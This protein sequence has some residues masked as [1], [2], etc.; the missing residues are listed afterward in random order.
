RAW[1]REVDSLATPEVGCLNAGLNRRRV[2]AE[3]VPAEVR[4]RYRVSALLPQVEAD[5]P[6]VHAAR[7]MA[8]QN[9][10]W[11]LEN[12]NRNLSGDFLEVIYRMAAGQRPTADDFFISSD[13][14]AM[15]LDA[16]GLKLSRESLA[17]SLERLG[18][19]PALLD[20]V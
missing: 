19:D 3:P 7:I 18:R 8:H 16:V 5:L 17:W 14:G 15:S 12:S 10:N 11:H 6:L 4:E 1:R 20:Y 13:M 2:A 9:A